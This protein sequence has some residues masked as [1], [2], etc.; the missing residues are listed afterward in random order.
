M[1]SVNAS[2]RHTKSNPCRICG[3]H[4][5]MPQG[6]GERCWGYLSDDAQY[7]YCTR[8]EYAGTLTMKAGAEGYS[9]KLH[10]DCR[11]GDSHD[12]SPSAPM[13]N[14]NGKA[15]GNE[16]VIVA[17]YD[18]LN[19]KSEVVFQTV[20]YDPKGFSQ[21]HICPDGQTTW[22]LGGDP[23]KCQCP[24]INPILYRQPELLAADP[25]KPVCI[26]EGE[27]HADRLWELGLVPLPSRWVR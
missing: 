4:K 12:G 19:Q 17:V 9:H 23:A 8:S 5:D 2:Q 1:M 7:A 26:P 20:R 16:R 24:K 13:P 27:K 6:Q 3:G 10:G 18:Y 25:N 15:S 14:N 11:C 22:N 21:R